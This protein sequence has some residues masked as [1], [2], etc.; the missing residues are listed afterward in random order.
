MYIIARKKLG[1]LYIFKNPMLEI[2]F[3][4]FFTADFFRAV[5]KLG[6]ARQTTNNCQD[7]HDIIVLIHADKININI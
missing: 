7:L 4:N 6:K 2:L 3:E 5:D 1:W